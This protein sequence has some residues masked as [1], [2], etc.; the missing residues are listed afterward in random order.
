MP[1]AISADTGC[2]LHA[3]AGT[4]AI[5]VMLIL[6]VASR[7]MAGAETE[8]LFIALAALFWIG[9]FG[10]FAVLYGPLILRRKPTRR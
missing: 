10:G 4:S 9:A 5:N 2:V 6:S 8:G 3:G 7:L 1:Q